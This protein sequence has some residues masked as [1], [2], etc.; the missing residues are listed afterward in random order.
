MTT[1]K[2]SNLQLETVVKEINRFRSMIED[3][4]EQ[5]NPAPS[6]EEER[7]WQRCNPSPRDRHADDIRNFRRCVVETFGHDLELQIRLGHIAPTDI[8]DALVDLGK[9]CVAQCLLLDTDGN[10]QP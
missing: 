10:S 4:Y 5:A 1:T 6:W 7:E 8:Y 9:R 3:A 2:P